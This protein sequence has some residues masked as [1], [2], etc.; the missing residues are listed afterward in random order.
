MA[1]TV[2]E[3]EEYSFAL[4][5]VGPP[6]TYPV[7]QAIP[8]QIDRIPVASVLHDATHSVSDRDGV[9]FVDPIESPVVR[10]HRKMP[11]FEMGVIGC[12]GDGV[13]SSGRL[14][15]SP[16]FK[17]SL[18]FSGDTIPPPER[19]STES[20]L[21]SEFGYR[22]GP[23]EDLEGGGVAVV[24]EEGLVGGG[25]DVVGGEGNTA[26]I[27]GEAVVNFQESEEEEEEDGGV[28]GTTPGTED[29]GHW[30]RDEC[31]RSNR[32]VKKGACYR[33]YKGNRFT[34]K[35]VCIVCDAKYCRLCVFRAMGSMPEGRK[36]ASCIGYPIHE[37]KREMLGKCSR[38][39]KK[40]LSPLEIEQIMK[41]EKYC[42]VNQLQSECVCVNG[43]PLSPEEMVLLQSC[44]SP[45]RKLKP[46]HFWYDKVSGYWGKVNKHLLLNC[47]IKNVLS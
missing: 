46:G 12:E 44:G 26:N 33:C 22:S 39:L 9:P 16:E 45:P 38:M 14:D 10:Q 35:E 5:Y 7:P 30:G 36:C 27:R 19:V 15:E 47:N 21:S 28:E 24:L 1:A 25:D 18:D 37:E 4:E 23:D 17:E 20:V 13:S 2:A 41:A 42:E 40:L 43:N 32:N 31:H 34:A 8:I 3:A 11:L 6:L 29:F